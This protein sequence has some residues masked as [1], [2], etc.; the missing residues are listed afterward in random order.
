MAKK[1]GKKKEL[2]TVDRNQFNMKIV[3]SDVCHACKHKCARGIRYMEAMAQPGALGRGV[4]CMLTK[5]KGY[6]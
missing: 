4:P 5:G 3:T 6:K 1:T 2:S